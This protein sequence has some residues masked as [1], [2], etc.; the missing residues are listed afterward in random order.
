MHT[1]KDPSWILKYMGIPFKDHG[2][3]FDGCDCW[4]LV[5]LIYQNELGILL[6]HYE[7]HYTQVTDKAGTVK[8]QELARED[9]WTK[10]EGPVELGVVLLKV[11]GLPVHIGVVHNKDWFVHSSE[12]DLSRRVRFKDRI[13]KNRIEGFYVYG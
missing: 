4:G 7:E 1:D 2:R 3:D 10:T 6:P 9:K 11:F 12:G 8:V 5:R 13:W